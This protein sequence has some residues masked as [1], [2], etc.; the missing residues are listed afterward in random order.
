MNKRSKIYA[1]YVGERNVCDGTLEEISKKTGM[2]MDYLH[3]M[4]YP[5]SSK[6][7][8]G[9][10]KVPKCLVFIGEEEPCMS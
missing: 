9:R 7:L 2:T 6:R 3:W 4:T 1:L 8:L 5:S 10:K